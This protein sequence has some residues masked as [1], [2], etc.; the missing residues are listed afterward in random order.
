MFIETAASK[1]LVMSLTMTIRITDADIPEWFSHGVR[2]CLKLPHKRERHRMFRQVTEAH[3]A[4]HH[5]IDIYKNG[6]DIRI[7]SIFNSGIPSTKAAEEL[8]RSQGHMAGCQLDHENE[9]Q[10][11]VAWII[12]MPEQEAIAHA[13]ESLQY[14]FMT[15]EEHREKTRLRRTSRQATNASPVKNASLSPQI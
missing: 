13:W 14:M 4:I 5:G 2:C 1:E 6:R 10:D 12:D 9:I 8:I 11:V 7:E 3:L 15:N